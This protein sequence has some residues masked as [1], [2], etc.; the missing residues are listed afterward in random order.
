MADT[1]A[2]AKQ[3]DHAE[4][5]EQITANI[6][7][8]V[9]LAE[10]ENIEG[11]TELNKETETLISS[12]PS[13]GKIPDGSFTW[14]GYKKAARDDM[15]KASQA[16]PKPEPKSEASSAE[17][18]TRDY[19]SYEGVSE[20]VSMGA[21]K[22][23]EGVRLHAT[24]NSLAKEIAQI[25]LDIA[26]RIPNNDGD[27]DLMIDS[28]EAKEA[29]RALYKQAGEAFEHTFENEKS[30]KSLQRSVQYY[31]SDARAQ[32]LRSLD[33]DSEEAEAE[34]QHFAELIATNTAGGPVSEF[35]AAHYGTALKGKGE[36]EAEKWR[37][38]NQ[39]GELTAGNAE[40]EASEEADPNEKVKTV[41][42]S[43]LKDVKR[44]LPD[45]FEKASDETKAEVRNDLLKIADAVKAMIAAT[46]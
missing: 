32:Y 17:V 11:L 43:F 19:T 37:R 7:R 12:L 1:E 45:D 6:E 18:A 26:R 2:P 39:P 29:M 35:L 36:L 31:R 9:S 4:T 34:R 5:I 10:A 16:Q 20:L 23:A 40:G 22:V 28:A 13:R 41:V 44:A 25:G 33:G 38:E 14:A 27:P 3:D 42:R 8:A 15:R 21:E 46:I 24:G 30:L